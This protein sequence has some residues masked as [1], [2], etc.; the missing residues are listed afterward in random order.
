MAKTNTRVSVGVILLIL[1]II[2]IILTWPRLELQTKFHGGQD[3]FTIYSSDELKLTVSVWN[4]GGT[5]SGFR[6]ITPESCVSS[7]F[8]N[9]ITCTHEGFSGTIP[10]T[11]P[12]CGPTQ[13]QESGPVDE[14]TFGIDERN[15]PTNF[16]IT[17]IG[18]SSFSFIPIATMNESYICSINENQRSYNCFGLRSS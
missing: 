13:V 17:L 6:I 16:T 11:T 3:E 5:I 15:K 8:D 14:M 1:G 9:N 2:L 10:C 7:Y 12:I 18:T 4:R